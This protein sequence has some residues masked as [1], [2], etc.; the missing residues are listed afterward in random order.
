METLA[1]LDARGPLEPRAN[2]VRQLAVEEGGMHIRAAKEI[3]LSAYTASLL[4]SL[5][6]LQG[7]MGDLVA[8]IKP[9]LWTDGLADVFADA[10]IMEALGNPT[11]NNADDLITLAQGAVPTQKELYKPRA[12]RLHNRLKEMIGDDRS[13]KAWYL[14]NCSK[15]SSLWISCGRFLPGLAA[16]LP[17]ADFAINMRL[18]LLQSPVSSRHQP[19][20]RCLC[21]P[22]ALQLPLGQYH[23]FSCNAAIINI[24]RQVDRQPNVPR[25]PKGVAIRRHNLIRNALMD[26][27]DAAC[28][29]ANVFKEFNLPIGVR[30]IPGVR[31]IALRADVAVEF[32]GDMFYLDVVVTNPASQSCLQT[33]HPDEARL[34]AATMAEHSKESKYRTNYPQLPDIPKNLVPFAVEATGSLGKQADDFV[35]TLSKLREAVP[36]GNARLAWARRFFLNKV[37]MLCA[38]A[39][40]DMVRLGQR[41]QRVDANRAPA[42][43]YTGMR[44]EDVL[45][46]DVEFDDLGFFPEQVPQPSIHSQAGE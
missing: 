14:S 4:G 33:R 46:Q 9:S 39:R 31:D 16:S 1:E 17:H 25:G 22:N 35:K 15:E 5:K 30:N 26:F 3:G 7:Q 2:L 38:K 18:Q 23:C 45:T 43:R 10:D 40:A 11:L 34:V 29:G 6:F 20:V 41:I 37:S 28:P 42:N 8:K 19:S 27:V 36:A 21:G 44:A 12:K 32:G 13:M 24:N